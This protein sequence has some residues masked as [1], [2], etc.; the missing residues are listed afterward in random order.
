MA[1]SL[2][3]EVFSYFFYARFFAIRGWQWRFECFEDVQTFEA[4]D[5]FCPRNEL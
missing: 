2:G 3:D 4:C 5:A 1:Q